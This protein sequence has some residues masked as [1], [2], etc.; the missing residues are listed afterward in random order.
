MLPS[1]FATSVPVV[2][3]KSPVSE[4]VAVVV[5][6]TNLSADSSHAIMALSPVEPLSI[7]IP[8]SLAFEVAPEFNSNKL[9]SNVVLVEFTVVVEPLTVKL[10]DSVKLPNCTLLD[11][12]NA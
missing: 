8:V 11:V 6:T 3:D 10:P 1:I 4:A 12:A 5:P 7:M 2:I 9:S